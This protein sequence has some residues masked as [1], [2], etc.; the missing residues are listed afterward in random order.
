MSG[1]GARLPFVRDGV[2]GFG[3]LTDIN[4]VAKQ[5]LKMVLLTVPG[6]RIMDPNFGV[7]LKK[8]LFEPL[9]QK[10]MGRI[11]SKIKKQAKKYL[12]YINISSVNFTSAGKSESPSSYENMDPNFLGISIRFK[13]IPSGADSI[14]NLNF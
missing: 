11:E 7:G 12:P 1:F 4:S 2:Y 5:N 14:L 8:F 6:E 13:V 10:T 3:T 9:N